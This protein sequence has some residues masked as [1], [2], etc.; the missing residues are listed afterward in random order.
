[1]FKSLDYLSKFCFLFQH[2][3]H[4]KTKNNYKMIPDSS[5]CHLTL[6][7]TSWPLTFGFVVGELV[8][9]EAKPSLLEVLHS[10]AVSPLCSLD[11]ESGRKTDE[12]GQL[13]PSTDGLTV[14]DDAVLLQ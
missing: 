1:M 13:K 9:G 11:H 4:S 10:K 5:G 2:S 7:G 12:R 3:N 6:C 8:V 14:F